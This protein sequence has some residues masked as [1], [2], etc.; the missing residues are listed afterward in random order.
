ML[1]VAIG[2]KSAGFVDGF[3]VSE[4]IQNSFVLSGNIVFDPHFSHII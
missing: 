3:L 1:T 4:A 2:L